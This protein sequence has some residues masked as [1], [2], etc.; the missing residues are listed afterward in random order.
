[1]I[2]F[3]SRE[4]AVEFCRK[5][6]FDDGQMDELRPVTDA[7]FV[8]QI[9]G[10]R[11]IDRF[12]FTLCVDEKQWDK[13]AESER[14]NLRRHQQNAGLRYTQ[15][16]LPID[17][18]GQQAPVCLTSWSLAPGAQATTFRMTGGKF[19]ATPGPYADTQFTMA[20]FLMVDCTSMERAI[21]WGM[22]LVQHS[23]QAVEI[24]RTYGAWF[25]YHG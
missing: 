18:E 6:L 19:L 17:E 16:S 12:V 10:R 24:R 21:E 20:G 1:V 23:A 2:D 11:N 3:A 4:E 9:A 22:Q 13:M 14:E 15:A 25:V 8:A 7:W 5:R